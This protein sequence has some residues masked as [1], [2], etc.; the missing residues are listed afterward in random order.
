MIANEETI[1]AHFA[2]YTT[3]T[4]E[5]LLGTRPNPTYDDTGNGMLLQAQKLLCFKDCGILRL[6]DVIVY[7]NT[8][9]R[10]Q[11]GPGRIRRSPTDK[12]DQQHDDITGI[13]AFF[14]TDSHGRV[15]IQE[16]EDYLIAN[17]WWYDLNKRGD[18]KY[19]WGWRLA[20]RA[21]F[22]YCMKRPTSVW[23]R[24]AWAATVS[25]SGSGS[26]M[27]QDP[28][29]LTACL[30]RAYECSG[31]GTKLCDRAVAGWKIRLFK[32]W[33]PTGLRA[34][35]QKY[36][37]GNADHPL[38]VWWQWPQMDLGVVAE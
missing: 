33:G 12:D 10:S 38:A 18:W 6:E 3:P 34:V 20:L 36:H 11:D 13:T 35:Y 24:A 37:S 16:I 17:N 30:I 1:R 29:L 21:H 2:R 22:D 25:L 4:P 5:S 8:I 9:R 31:Q 32:K 14:S 19:W 15:V 27:S 26:S 7:L 28:W 23:L